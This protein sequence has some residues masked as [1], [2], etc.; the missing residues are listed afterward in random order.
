MFLKCKQSAFI[1]VF[2]AQVVGLRFGLRSE[3]FVKTKLLK[4][5]F[6]YQAQLIFLENSFLSPMFWRKGFLSLN[7]QA[8]IARKIV[9]Q[10][11]CFLN[12]NSRQSLLFTKI[13]HGLI[14]KGSGLL[15]L[16]TILKYLSDRHIYLIPD[17]FE[18]SLYYLA[19][20]QSTV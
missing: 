13:L 9:F 11:K 4:F 20:K 7:F 15:S 18:I 10:S 1:K 8:Q 19:Q 2:K 14:R 5:F 17:Y 6:F 16:S 12:P 3:L